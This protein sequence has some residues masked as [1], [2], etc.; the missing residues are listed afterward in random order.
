MDLIYN[1]SNPP[2][3]H[4]D[5]CL[6][7]YWLFLFFFFFFLFHFH[8]PNFHL[9]YWSSPRRSALCPCLLSFSFRQLTDIMSLAAL[10]PSVASPLFPTSASSSPSYSCSFL[11]SR[12]TQSAAEIADSSLQGDAVLCE[13]VCLCRLLCAVRLDYTSSA[14]LSML[15]R[16]CLC[17]FLNR[18]YRQKSATNWSSEAIQVSYIARMNITHLRHSFRP[19]MCESTV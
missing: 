3:I 7:S 11:P 18:N 17:A 16:M 19:F 12:T 5:L 4:H 1:S 10:L 2:S 8:P 14:A 15:L 9:L 13:S 6:S